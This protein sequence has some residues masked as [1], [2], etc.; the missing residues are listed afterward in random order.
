[1][2]TG[3]LTSFER[4]IRA[5]RARL[6]RYK[7]SSPGQTDFAFMDV[8]EAEQQI[9]A[10]RPAGQQPQSRESPSPSSRETHSRVD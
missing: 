9:E 2:K 7:E 6:P 3:R 5:L 8:G 1:M 10:E 4:G